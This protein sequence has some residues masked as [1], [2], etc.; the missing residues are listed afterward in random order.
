M[1]GFIQYT[2]MFYARVSGIIE[3]KIKDLQVNEN[4]GKKTTV[5]SNSKRGESTTPYNNNLVSTQVAQDNIEQ[6][7]Y[8]METNSANIIDNALKLSQAAV[9]GEIDQYV[10]SFDDLF[11]Q[12]D[13]SKEINCVIRDNLLAALKAVAELSKDSGIKV[14]TFA[15]KLD[16]LLSHLIPGPVGPEGPVGPAGP[17]G[18][19]G[20]QGERGEQGLPGKSFTPKGTV[21]TAADL[22]QVAQTDDA[23]VTVDLEHM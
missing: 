17:Q 15:A 2:P 6:N 12:I 8:N 4:V 3:D 18:I 5:T 1:N 7:Q 19:Q 10:H 23:Y 13:M 21:A 9:N 14:D 20:I 22:P 16:E 11:T